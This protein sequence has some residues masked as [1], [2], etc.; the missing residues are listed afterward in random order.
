IAKHLNKQ[1]SISLRVNPD[2]N[3]QTHPYISTGLNENKFGI[4]YDKAFGLY[5]WAKKQPHLKITGIASH[6][7]S[8][9]T[10]LTPFIDALSRIEA[11]IDKLKETQI[12]LS[13]IDIGGGLGVTYDKET[14]PTPE[15]YANTIAAHRRHTDLELILEPGRAIIANAGILL[16]R[17][18]T[19]KKNAKKGFCIVDAGMNDLIR[20]S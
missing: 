9:I 16:T 2:V 15:M 19:I 4:E 10:E 14:P 17:V 5:E 11:L 7:G 13:S 6:I 8:Q 3:P 12:Q 18:I 1:A 20:P